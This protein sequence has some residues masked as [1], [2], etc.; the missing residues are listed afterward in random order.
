[1]CHSYIEI[2][3][4]AP[5]LSLHLSTGPQSR[6]PTWIPHGGNMAT[7][8]PGAIDSHCTFLFSLW[9]IVS[10]LALVSYSLG[11]AEWVSANESILLR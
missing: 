4:L 10:S 7:P 6:S 1:M 5:I 3:I 2:K 8:I 11:P 9:N